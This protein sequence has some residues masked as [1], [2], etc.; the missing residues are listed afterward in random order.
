MAI[1]TFMTF[2]MVESETD[3]GEYEKLIDIKSFPNLGGTPELLET[4]TLSDYMTTNILGI[5]TLDALEFTTNYTKAERVRLEPYIGVDRNY[6]V[7]LGGTNVGG[8]V[9]PTGSEGKYNY[10][11]AMSAFVVGAGVNAVVDMNITIAASKPIIMVD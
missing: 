2:L 6:S 10:S 1:S 5:Q 9:T 11:G 3:P 8:I 7:W 4:T